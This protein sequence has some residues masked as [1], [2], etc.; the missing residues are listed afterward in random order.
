MRANQVVSSWQ[1]LQD[2]WQQKRDQHAA[3]LQDMKRQ[4][5]EIQAREIWPK[6]EPSGKE[7]QSSQLQSHVHQLAQLSHGIVS[8]AQGAAVDPAA[9]AAQLR[10]ATQAL[11][12]THP[13]ITM[14]SPP[15]TINR[16]PA[17]APTV[18][19]SSGTIPADPKKQPGWQGAAP[20]GG[21]PDISLSGAPAPA[22]ALQ[23]R[24]E[25]A[26]ESG[27][28]RIRPHSPRRRS[29]V[30]HSPPSPGYLDQLTMSDA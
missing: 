17:P 24:E 25:N 30:S 21:H 19:S 15:T 13:A 22:K 4:L 3:E 11:P 9:F 26:G 18:P 10:N 7:Q 14:A 20:L 6:L 5:V 12:T 23:A 27:S 28:R 16:S 1:L 2:A 29:R 8:T